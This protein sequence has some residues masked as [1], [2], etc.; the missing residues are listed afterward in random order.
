MIDI[1]FSFQA[2][3]NNSNVGLQF[4]Q[5][6]LANE[7]NLH[8]LI[9]GDCKAQISMP[10]WCGRCNKVAYCNE[11]CQQTACGIHKIYCFSRSDELDLRERAALKGIQYNQRCHY[12]FVQ[13]G[14]VLTEQGRLDEAEEAFKRAFHLNKQSISQILD[15]AK[16][17]VNKGLLEEADAVFRMAARIDPTIFT[18]FPEYRYL[19]RKYE[20]KFSLDIA[21]SNFKGLLE[22]NPNNDGALA[23]LSKLLMMSGCFDEASE[24]ANAALRI[25]NKNDLACTVLGA[26]HYKLAAIVGNERKIDQQN[27]SLAF[28]RHFLNEAIKLNPENAWAYFLL[29]LVANQQGQVEEAH[30]DLQQAAA[31]D[32]K[33]QADLIQFENSQHNMFSASK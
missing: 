1:T 24:N 10:L 5:H 7:T 12:S 20:H 16:M 29:A 25:N 17:L 31:L 27:H 2:R 3:T 26:T 23:H 21:M 18:A 6:N 30:Q 32:P 4:T 19:F 13:L 22:L 8:A 11:M 9:C 15:F 28:A 33:Y 14:G